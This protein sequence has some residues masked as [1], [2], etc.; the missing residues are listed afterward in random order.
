[1]DKSPDYCSTSVR[2]LF[3]QIHLSSMLK[4]TCSGTAWK[5]CRQREMGSAWFLP[6]DWKNWKTNQ[7]V[8]TKRV[9]L[10][11]WRKRLV[12]VHFVSL[13]QNFCTQKERKTQEK[14]DGDHTILQWMT[15]E[16]V[17][18]AGA[19]PTHPCH[20]LLSAP[21]SGPTV[22]KEPKQLM[23]MTA[24]VAHKLVKPG[25]SFV[26]KPKTASFTLHSLNYFNQN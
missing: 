7:E 4:P 26:C 10:G 23:S 16:S 12:L 11:E 15:Y 3:W 2:T 21:G 20:H 22:G 17:V 24:P 5:I 25:S 8:R 9:Y 18:S 14:D 6:N 19:P 13:I 1:M